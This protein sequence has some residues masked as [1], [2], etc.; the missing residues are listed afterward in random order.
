[1]ERNPFTYHQYPDTPKTPS[2]TSH[3]ITQEAEVAT[4]TSSENSQCSDYGTS[5]ET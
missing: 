1:M 2:S 4:C 5:S 3:T